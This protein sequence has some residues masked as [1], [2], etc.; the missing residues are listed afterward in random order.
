MS[1]NENSRP[2]KDTPKPESAVM[3]ELAEAVT[4]DDLE[5]DEE[6]L[7]AE[8]KRLSQ[9]EAETEA[10]ITPVE[11]EMV[12]EIG[13]DPV[14]LYLKEIGRVDLLNPDEEF[15]LATC[16]QAQRRIENLSQQH[17]QSGDSTSLPRSVYL[18]LYDELLVGWKR[19]QEDAK[20]MKKPLP[21]L[22]QI[23]DEARVLRLNWDLPSPSY[24]RAYLDNGL[25]GK[26]EQWD[27]VARNAF[28]VILGHYTLPN[29]VAGRVREFIEKRE[30]LPTKR[31]F[32]RY[33]PAD[34]ELNLE[35]DSI[36]LRS[37][38]AES[39]LVRANL[40]LVV[41]V[42]KRYTGRGSSF[43]DLIQEGNIG[44][45]RAVSKFDPTRG[46]KFS[47]YATWWIRQAITRS[48]ADQARTIRIPVHLIEQI[49]RLVRAQRSLTQ[50]LGREPNHEE[51]A[52]EA[53]F[54]EPEDTKLIRYYQREG[55]PLDADLGRRLRRA[56]H[57]VRTVLRNAE[58]PMSLDIPVGNEE[59]S[60]LGDFIPDDDA[61]AP[62]DAAAREILREQVQSALSVLN[63]RERQVLELRFGLVDGKDHTLEE[64]GKYFNV[65]RERIRQIEAKALR[66]LRHPTRSRHLRDYLG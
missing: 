6:A 46:F 11:P 54:L 20:R 37:D 13:D 55:I 10:A 60:Q 22:L 50:T 39:A 40:R 49:H 1:L 33:L 62:S 15:G 57:K 18:T 35:L 58:E 7:A 24:L 23:L 38:D 21:D 9:A 25:W 5:P 56:A 47:T 48:I 2:A 51:L 64:V 52:L 30:K 31:T 45:L 41:S 26:D 32:G 29:D 8:L 43:L 14:R 34:E 16:M 3:Q 66:K 63:P 19:V 61:I 36:Q 44:L 12:F 27:L 42:A 53:G 4:Q 17:R 28:A 65:T 59:S